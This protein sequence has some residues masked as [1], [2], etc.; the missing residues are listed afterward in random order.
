MTNLIPL[1]LAFAD[2]QLATDG[3][4]FIQAKGQMTVKCQ[5]QW[6]NFNLT[7]AANHKARLRD[8]G[9]YGFRPA[10]L[11]DGHTWQV[12]A[13]DLTALTKVLHQ[14]HWAAD[15]KDLETYARWQGSMTL[16]EAL[17]ADGNLNLKLTTSKTGFRAAIDGTIRVKDTG[18]LSNR[19]GPNGWEKS[20]THKLR[21]SVDLDKTGQVTLVELT[22]DFEVTGGFTNQPDVISDPASQ[23]GNLTVRLFFPN[24]LSPEDAK[25]V[26]KLVAQLGAK[27]FAVRENATKELNN[28]GPRIANLLR[29]LAPAYKDPEVRKRVEELLKAFP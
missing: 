11:A 29:E 13:E 19:F 21:G 6:H 24:P 27:D 22:D 26:E 15:A 17:A 5:S 7:V 2:P 20:W 4:R 18:R 12:A 25:Q 16:Q 28:M 23:K 14:I 9:M 1:L 10:R 8:A 3:N